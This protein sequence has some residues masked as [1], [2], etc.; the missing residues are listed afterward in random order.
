MQSITRRINITLPKAILKQLQREVP[1]GT[2]SRFIA[3]AVSEKLAKK[4]HGK[5]SLEESLRANYAFYKK[6]GKIWDVTVADG[7]DQWPWK[8]DDER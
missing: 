5:L 4:Q 6:E 3:K 1:K 2:R 7:L 8:E